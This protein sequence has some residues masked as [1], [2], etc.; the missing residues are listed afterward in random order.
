MKEW[1]EDRKERYRRREVGERNTR[2]EKNGRKRRE[3]IRGLKKE[4]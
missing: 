4:V 2:Q 3:D 1:G